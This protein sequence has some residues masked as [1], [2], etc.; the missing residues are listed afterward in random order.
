MRGASINSESVP[1][2]ARPMTKATPTT[3]NFIVKSRLHGFETAILELS[4]CGVCDVEKQ[5]ETHAG[6]SE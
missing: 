6:G 2:M 4:L 1:E 3:L 5:E